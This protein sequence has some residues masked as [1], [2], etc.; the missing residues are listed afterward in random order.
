MEVSNLFLP[1]D[2]I[3]V[4]L[5]SSLAVVHRDYL[6]RSRKGHSFQC[7]RNWHFFRLNWR[8]IGP[9]G[10]ALPN[11]CERD[12]EWG[13]LSCRTYFSQLSYLVWLF[14]NTLIKRIFFSRIITNGR[15]TLEYCEGKHSKRYDIGVFGNLKVVFGSN[16][17]LWFLPIC[18]LQNQFLK[19]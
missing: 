5:I 17:L 14:E 6:S 11:T 12:L 19:D 8:F 9:T 15:T 16:V 4:F 10:K 7:E 18:I 2:L 1:S 3:S 13:S